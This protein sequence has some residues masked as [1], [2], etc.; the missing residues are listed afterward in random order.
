M[1]GEKKHFGLALGGGAARGIAHIG[2]LKALDQ[3]GLKPSFVAGTSVGSLIGALYCAG[4]SWQQI[5]QEAEDLDWPDLVKV[6]MPRMGLV[7][8]DKLETLVD[9]LLEGKSIEE[10]PVPFQAV[11]VDLVSGKEAILT[12]GPVGRAVRASCSLPGIFTP[13]EDG[14]R[15]L[16]DGG[17]VNNLPA[18]QVREMGADY[19]VAVDLAFSGWDQRKK[20][21][22]LLEVLLTSTFI[23]MGNTGSQGRHASDLLVVPELAGFGFHDMS[24]KQEM[25]DLGYQAMQSKLEALVSFPP[26]EQ[27]K[28]ESQTSG[29]YRRR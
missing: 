1:F 19:V 22:N 26:A 6:T 28:S 13:M 16:A 3:A 25:L 21:S 9:T 8:A 27:D 20:P 24:R 4:L 23:L 17:I 14:V 12:S 5:W 10:L 15:L 29:H 18:I 11:A 2:V 7:N